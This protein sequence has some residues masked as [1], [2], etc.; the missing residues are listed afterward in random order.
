MTGPPLSLAEGFVVSAIGVA[1]LLFAFRKI[2]YF[3]VGW[4]WPLPDSSTTPRRPKGGAL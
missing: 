1:V 2:F 3:V 4:I